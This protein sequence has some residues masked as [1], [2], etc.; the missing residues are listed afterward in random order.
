VG[1]YS[2]PPDLLAG[3]KGTNEVIWKTEKGRYINGREEQSPPPP[4]PGSAT[5][6]TCQ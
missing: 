1:A 3:F 5:D 2:T 6:N 4:I